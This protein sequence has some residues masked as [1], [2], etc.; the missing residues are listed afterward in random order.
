M[1]H[2]ARKFTTNIYDLK[3]IYTTFIISK[4]EHSAVVWHSS[5]TQDN[6]SDLERVQK[7]AVKIIM[8]YKYT[9]YNNSLKYLKLES[10]D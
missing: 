1:L 6:R 5:L 10:L 8:G 4:V 9:D 3:Q 2:A 7:A